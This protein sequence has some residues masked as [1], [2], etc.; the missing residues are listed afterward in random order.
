[1][2]WGGLLGWIFLCFAVA[3]VSGAWTARE[4]TGWYR[5]LHRPSFAPP[6]WVFGPVWSLLYLLMAIAAWLVWAAPGSGARSWGLGLFLLQLALNFAW[7]WIFFRK[8]AI[9]TALVEVVLLWAAIGATLLA[10]TRV[11]T[12]AAWLMAPYLAWVS[13]AT[14]LNAG[15]WRLNGTNHDGD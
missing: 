14:A 6:N 15:F 10:F 3:G 4:I 7:S 12:T 8:H 1:M 5:T 2:R 11:S 13:F 9:G